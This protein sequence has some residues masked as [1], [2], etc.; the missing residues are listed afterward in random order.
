MTMYFKALIATLMLYTSNVAS[1]VSPLFR[2][3]LLPVSSQ[4]TARYEAGSEFGASRSLRL[5][6][7]CGVNN[8][9]VHSIFFFRPSF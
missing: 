2:D 5:L 7:R 3:A 4:P 1:V 8:H 6:H 9:V